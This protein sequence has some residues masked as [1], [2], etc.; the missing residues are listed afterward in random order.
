MPHIVRVGSFAEI[1]A[2]FLERVHRIVWCAFAT[3]DTCNRV[4]SRILHPIWEGST[5]WIATRRH[6]PKAKNLAHN[7]YVSL[8]YVVDI[9][10][11]VYADC[12]AEWEDDIRSKRR[13]WELLLSTPPPLGYDPAPT[14]YSP[15]HPDFGLLRLTPWQ[16]TLADLPAESR[17]WRK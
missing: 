12:L 7:P 8:A 6:S 15:D 1:E 11:P 16:V 10:R 17:V 5:G 3:L 13:V 2:E 9:A 14:F 4:R